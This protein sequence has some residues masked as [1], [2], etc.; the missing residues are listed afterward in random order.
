MYCK[1]RNFRKEFNFVAFVLN[2]EKRTKLN[3]IPNFLPCPAARKRVSAQA[4]A[5]PVILKVR[6]IVPCER[7][8][9]EKYEI[10]R[11]RKFLLLLGITIELNLGGFRINKFKLQVCALLWPPLLRRR[12]LIKLSPKLLQEAFSIQAEIYDMSRV[13]QRACKLNCHRAQPG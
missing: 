7:F 9:T 2:I 8:S 1:G 3:T 5:G 10:F 6:N 4:R 12:N 11:L 13:C